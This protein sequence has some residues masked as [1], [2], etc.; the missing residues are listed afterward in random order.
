M[1]RLGNGLTAA[2]PVSGP[3]YPDANVFSSSASGRTEDQNARDASS[4][5]AWPPESAFLQHC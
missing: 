2:A 1:G 4:L 3:F 5:D